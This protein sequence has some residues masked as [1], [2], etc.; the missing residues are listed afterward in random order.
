MTDLAS[1][2]LRCPTCGA[3]Q[4]WSSECRRCRSDLRLL[5][6][7]AQRYRHS[8]SRCLAELRAG[9]PRAALL[10]ARDCLFLSPSDDARRLEAVCALRAGDWPAAVAAARLIPQRPDAE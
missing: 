1:E 9:R 6:E 8:R 10:H 4:G 3:S 2:V 7:A 5:Q